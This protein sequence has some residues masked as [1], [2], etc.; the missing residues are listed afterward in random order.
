MILYHAL[1]DYDEFIDPEKYGLISKYI[2]E[3]V[4]KKV[5]L[6]EANKKIGFLKEDELEKAILE[7][8]T[9]V[10]KMVLDYQKQVES[11]LDL[12]SSESKLLRGEAASEV[13]HIISSVDDKKDKLHKN[14]IT[15]S[16]N[17]LDEKRIY[18]EQMVCKVVC[19]D[20]EDGVESLEGYPKDF[21]VLMG[22]QVGYYS[23]VPD[24]KIAATLNACEYERLIYGIS[25]IDEILTTKKK[26]EEA[27][28]EYISNLMSMYKN[29]SFEQFLIQEHLEKNRSLKAIS[30]D[31]LDHSTV[32]LAWF[33]N[34]SWDKVIKTY[35]KKMGLRN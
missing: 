35:K 27:N 32:N 22:K 11:Y 21:S 29:E 30:N 23:V 12:L 6:L 19:V 33:I 26:R 15:L 28:D 17:P 14:W 13:T 34:D 8:M 18:D 20:T 25:N 9:E 16:K 10:K 31:N 1:T 24:Y 3:E 2:V 4:V 7:S 5:Y